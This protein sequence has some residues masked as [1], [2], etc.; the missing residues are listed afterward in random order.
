MPISSRSF[1][2]S[3]CILGEGPLW[4]A[5][6]NSCFWVDIEKG[7]LYE[8]RF[9]DGQAISYCFEGRTSMVIESA[10]G[11]LII[12]LN[13]KIFKFHPDS[14]QLEFLYEVD[15]ELDT[16]RFNDG[17]ADSR[18]RIWA[19]TMHLSHLPGTGTLYCLDPR[20]RPE[21]KLEGL[22]ISNGIAWSPD[23]RH[24][25]FIDSPTHRIDAYFFNEEDG[26]IEFDRTA[27]RIPPEMGAPDGMAMDSEG[28][29]WVAQ[30]DGFG[31][32]HWDPQSGKLIDKIELPVPQTSSCAFV[33]QELDCLII[34][35]AREN[36]SEGELKKY[37]Q[38]GDCFI[39]EMPVKGQPVFK[40]KL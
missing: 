23:N 32:Y 29:L 31:V 37:P 10:Y 8:Y 34:T 1:Y 26:K 39:A 38:S 20:C 5:G 3:Q 14:G 6:R 16:H 11:H 12:T 27:I 25:F 9:S 36:M 24:M 21:P 19:G 30:W 18:G 33:G 28:M 15:P 40:C 22:A 7:I 4:H 2:P 35:T 17:T 13:R